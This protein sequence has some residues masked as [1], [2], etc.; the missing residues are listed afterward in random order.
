MSAL[1][2][3]TEPVTERWNGRKTATVVL[4]VTVTLLVA[5]GVGGALL[6]ETRYAVHFDQI[7]QAPS[8]RHPFGTDWLGRDMLFRTLKGL[9][10]SIRI[11]LFASVVSSVIALLLG[12]GAAVFGGWYDRVVLWLVDLMQGM[13]H[14]IFM[15][16]IAILVGRGIPGV[17]IWVAAT[18]WVSL[19][20]IVRAETIHLRTSPYVLASRQ[21]GRS[22]WFIA[23]RHYVPYIV[24]QTVVATVLLFP[25]A[26]LHESGLT[27][28][29][30]GIPVQMPAIGVI[31]SESMR[32]LTTGHWWLAVCPGLI[33]LAMVLVIDRCGNALSALISPSTAHR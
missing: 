3:E 15:I 12:I 17:M 9:S 25:H 20:R 14:L 23:W 10:I 33:L 4:A 2:L 27:F 24:P 7:N 21:M 28:L 5:A 16:F 8:L 1:L 32:Y 18:H 26:I 30:F 19:C 29:G 13:P 11:G 6:P 22:S 31:L